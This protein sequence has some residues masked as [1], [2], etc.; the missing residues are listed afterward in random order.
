LKI[1]SSKISVPTSSRIELINITSNISNAVEK[2]GMSE[3]IVLVYSPHTTTAVLIN[4]N[5]PR[6]LR[7][8]EKAVKQLISW[9]EQYAHNTI[10]DNAASHLTGAFIGNN[11]CLPIEKG[12][13]QLG[14]WQSIFLVELDGPRSRRIEVK[15]IG[16]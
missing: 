8:F 11:I 15:V 13:I 12:R 6:L 16:K 1:H 14:T 3:G 5:E 2:S 7:D 9:E 10:D 4:E